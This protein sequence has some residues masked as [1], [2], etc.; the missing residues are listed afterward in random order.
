MALL[1]VEDM[2]HQVSGGLLC[3]AVDLPA[4]KKNNLSQP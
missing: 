4:L 2:K 1:S 3:L